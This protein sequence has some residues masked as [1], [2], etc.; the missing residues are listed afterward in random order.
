MGEVCLKIFI[1]HY[2]VLFMKWLSLLF[3]LV[4]SYWSVSL[5]TAV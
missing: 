4:A 2:S 1:G 3:I 5:Y